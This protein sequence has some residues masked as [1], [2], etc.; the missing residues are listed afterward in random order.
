LAVA[1]I[2]AIFRKSKRLVANVLFAGGITFWIAAFLV[3]SQGFSAKSECIESLFMI[4]AAVDMLIKGA[5]IR[6]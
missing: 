2:V 6:R 3:A 4:Y 5:V 1:M